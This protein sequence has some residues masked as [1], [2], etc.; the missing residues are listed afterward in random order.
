MFVIVA[1]IQIKEGHRDAFIE[2]MIDDAK[3]LLRT[4]PVV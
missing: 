3:A 2:S 1:P 4:N